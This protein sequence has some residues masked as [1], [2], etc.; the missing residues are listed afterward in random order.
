MKKLFQIILISILLTNL[1]YGQN[2]A[3]EELIIKQI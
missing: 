1:S 2:A 3:T